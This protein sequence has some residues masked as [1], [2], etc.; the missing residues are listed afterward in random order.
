V[1]LS[2]VINTVELD[3]ATT[4]NKS[5]MARMA[6]L[7]PMN[8]NG[9]LDMKNAF[10]EKSVQ[11]LTCKKRKSRRQT[12][13]VTPPK[14]NTTPGKCHILDSTHMYLIYCE[15]IKKSLYSVFTEFSQTR[16]GGIMP[17]A[18]TSGACGQP[19]DLLQPP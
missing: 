19:P 17:R 11:A 10:G 2:P 1:Q 9:A 5:R 8:F 7:S 13:S 12:G 4:G 3:A 15:K 16:G 18:E 14:R 6:S